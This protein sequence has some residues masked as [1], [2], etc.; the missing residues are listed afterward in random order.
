MPVT[1]S[2]RS[3]LADRYSIERELGRGGMA[4]VYL[5]RDLKHDREVALKVLRADLSAV[6]G[7]ERFLAEIRITAKLDHPHILTLIDSGSAD[8]LLYYVLPYVRGESLRAKLS[9]EKQLGVEDALS[10]ITQV[11]S[12]LDY[13]HS[14]GVI[15][16][17]IKPENILLHEGEAMLA[18]F[19]IALAVKEAGRDRLTESGMSLGTPQYMSP[20]QATGDR[21][22][23]QRSDVY[24]L[25][26]VFYEMLSGEPPFTGATVPAIIAKLLTE[27]PVRL[28]VLRPIISLAM[29]RATEKALGKVPADRF[30]SAG[31][32]VR[33]LS[34]SAPVRAQTAWHVR[35]KW[36]ALSLASIAIV[37]SAVW[38]VRREPGAPKRSGVSLRQRTQLTNSG[39][40]SVPA[41]SGDGKTIAYA[42][43]ECTT[44]GCRYGVEMQDIAGGA[45]RRLVDG[46]TAVYRLEVSPDRRH[47]LMVGSVEGAWGQYLIPTLGGPPRLL[48][49]GVAA[50]WSGGDSLLIV[51]ESASA[52][53]FWILVCGL[54]GVPADSIRVEGGDNI[55]AVSAVPNSQRIAYTV[56][57]GKIQRW[58]SID[59]SGKTHSSRT[60]PGGTLRFG[61]TSSDALWLMMRTLG[62][63]DWSILRV[64]FESATGRFSKATDTV[65]TGD[66]TGFSVTADGETIL[67][68]V[69]TTEYAAWALP[70]ADALKGNFSDEKRLFRGTSPVRFS[71]SPEGTIVSLSR[72]WGT[73][74]R[75]AGQWVVV[76]FGGGKETPLPGRHRDVWFVDS[77]TLAIED[78]V[79]RG[80]QVSLMDYRT[81]GKS[82][83]ITIPD[84]IP[85]DVTRAPNVWV[86]LGVDRRTINVR[87]DGH[88]QP[89]RIA[90]PPWYALALTLTA[91]PDGRFIAFTGWKAS[92][93]DSL[94]VG[95]LSLADGRSSQVWTT[96]AE[97]GVATWLNDG[98]LLVEV[99]DTPESATFYRS[100]GPGRI[101]LLGSI[102]R[103]ITK[104]SASR[105]LRNVVVS[106]HDR[107]ADAWVSKVVR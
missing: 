70:F 11:A 83:Q 71:L 51:R 6:I 58:V 102:P 75:E 65:Y 74:N 39:R 57:N 88:S 18:D 89:R 13:A 67:M 38:L 46:A 95:T 97:G 103:P 20:E 87:R 91:S 68:D 94:G 55:D 28:R 92:T 107:H 22:L 98:S 15:H 37:G 47:V 30:F 59:R 73:L 4:T 10:I 78:A 44:R 34:A 66:L 76:P 81:K 61:L 42:V 99:L 69:G 52:P 12:A 72:D 3:A 31:E 93:Y 82:V 26:A 40:V 29:E 9:R 1:E 106:T 33:A 86:W 80:T 96:V 49:R 90:V 27:N 32:F 16:R 14:Q 79:A 19:G 7:S 8:G 60:F 5:A 41:M 53:M 85:I 43:T 48:S 35:G 62:R 2:L 64:P 54:D 17:D 56:L 25:G 63:P 84:S 24:S 23:D 50:F 45:A 101:E 100:R 77:T 104:T 36:V 105:D 21:V